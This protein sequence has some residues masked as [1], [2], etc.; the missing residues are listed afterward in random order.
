MSNIVINQKNTNNIQEQNNLQISKKEDISKKKVNFDN[1]FDNSLIELNTSSA[2]NNYNSSKKNKD[3]I[4]S[5]IKKINNVESKEIKV[6]KDDTKKI[7][8]LTQSTEIKNIENKYSEFESFINTE[9]KIGNNLISEIS[10]NH[11][12]YP[13]NRGMYFSKMDTAEKDYMSLM[14]KFDNVLLS[15]EK[16]EKLESSNEFDKQVGLLQKQKIKLIKNLEKMNDILNN[17]IEF[18]KINVK[19]PNFMKGEKYENPSIKKEIK[20]NESSNRSSQLTASL[21]DNRLVDIYKQDYLK[22]LKRYETVSQD[23]YINRI[24]ETL[25]KINNEIENLSKENRVLNNRQKSSESKFESKH[26]HYSQGSISTDLSIINFEYLNQRKLL[27]NVIDQIDKNKFDIKNNEDKMTDLSLKYNKYKEIAGFYNIQEENI[28]KNNKPKIKEK[29]VKVQKFSLTNKMNILYNASFTLKKKYE[30]YILKNEKTIFHLK[31]VKL[32]SVN[33]YKI[34][35]AIEDELEKEV[36]RLYDIRATYDDEK[37]LNSL[38]NKDDYDENF[39]DN[40]TPSNLK[41][42]VDHHSYHDLHRANQQNENRNKEM[43]NERIQFINKEEVELIDTIDKAKI[44][45][46][47][48]NHKNLKAIYTREN[49]IE[50]EDKVQDEYTKNIKDLKPNNRSDHQLRSDYGEENLKEDSLQNIEK[51]IIEK[52]SKK[53]DNT[54]KIQKN[55]LRTSN[56][57]EKSFLNKIKDNSNFKEDDIVKYKIMGEDNSKHNLLQNFDKSKNNN[58]IKEDKNKGNIDNLKENHLSSIKNYSKL[59]NPNEYL[60]S[61]AESEK[62]KI[63]ENTDDVLKKDRK[64]EK[65]ISENEIK[66]E[67]NEKSDKLKSSLKTNENNR[68][69]YLN[70]NNLKNNELNEKIKKKNENEQNN[71]IIKKEVK[72]LKHND[73]DDLI[74]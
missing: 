24:D 58:E 28:I 64:R 60:E 36:R 18:S 39:W 19:N 49:E 12:H 1:S 5:E 45:L 66:L 67:D 56:S 43:K 51:K 74:I 38:Q 50:N 40:E 34:K 59:E 63:K 37:F 62:V 14:K 72:K 21:G 71:N 31:N 22:Y 46:K 61:R 54:N 9:E 17:V 52:Y 32:Q 25:F 23:Q 47:D 48:Y 35:S 29:I 69:N 68:E 30:Q 73:F 10:I 57:N 3:E 6:K 70:D 20:S 42:S 41:R 2:N 33:L 65:K 44:F 55:D 53:T 15:D 7:N 8:P 16:I 4:D 13:T 26:N 11:N 27:D